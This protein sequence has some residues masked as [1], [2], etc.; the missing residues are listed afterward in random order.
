M[1]EIILASSSPRRQSLLKNLGIYFSTMSA[2]ID[3]NFLPQESPRDA[4]RRLARLKAERAILV[5][6]EDYLLIAADII[7]VLDG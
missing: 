4:V 5:L 3:E 2:N 7:V 6:K 1:K